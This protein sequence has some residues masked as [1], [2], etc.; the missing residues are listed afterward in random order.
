MD[1]PDNITFTIDEFKRLKKIIEVEHER[2]G[3]NKASE[4]LKSDDAIKYQIDKHASGHV[5]WTYDM[6]NW[7][8]T[9][10]ESILN[11]KPKSEDDTQV[12]E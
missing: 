1:E 7:L 6:G 9:R 4:A 12:S 5:L 8:E 2:V 10:Q 3:F 11:E